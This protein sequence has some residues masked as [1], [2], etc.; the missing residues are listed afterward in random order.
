[1]HYDSRPLGHAKLDTTARY[2]HVATKVLRDM[3][4]PLD[5]LSC[6]S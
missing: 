2:A 5:R 4:S 3:V 1:V 6:K